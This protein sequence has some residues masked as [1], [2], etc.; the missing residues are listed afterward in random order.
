MDVALAL[1]YVILET[2]L[3]VL[4]ASESLDAVAAVL[5]V[6]VILVEIETVA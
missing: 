6:A 3:E 4:V 2:R 1:E 5:G